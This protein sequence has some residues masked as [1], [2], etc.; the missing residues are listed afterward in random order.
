MDFTRRTK[1]D[2]PDLQL[3]LDGKAVPHSKVIIRHIPS[4]QDQKSEQPDTDNDQEL[5]LSLF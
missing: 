5:T 2:E 4:E 1:T 3:T